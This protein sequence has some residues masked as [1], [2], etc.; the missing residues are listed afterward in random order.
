MFRNLARGGDGDAAHVAQALLGGRQRIVA[1]DLKPAA[2]RLFAMAKPM[3]PAPTIPTFPCSALAKCHLPIKTKEGRRSRSMRS[4]A[5]RAR[6]HRRRGQ[7]Q[8]ARKPI[9]PSGAEAEEAGCG[10]DLLHQ[11]DPGKRAEEGTAPAENTRAAENHGRD[12]L[13]ACNS[14]R[15]SDRRRRLARRAKP[16]PKP[17]KK[18]R[19]HRREC[20]C[21]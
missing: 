14:G 16:R 4:G 11:N 15:R 7:D 2:R 18:S 12:A 10:R 19:A 6:I 17:R 3:T 9:L 8:D 5:A 1:E 20:S 21:G 13:Q